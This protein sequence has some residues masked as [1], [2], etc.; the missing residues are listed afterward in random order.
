MKAIPFFAVLAVWATFTRPVESQQARAEVL[1]LG[2]YH[3][4]NPGRDVF[5]TQVD[6][7]LSPRRQAEMTELI[8]VL[9]KFNPTK[10]AVEANF[11]EQRLAQQ[12]ADYRAGKC[13]LSRNEIQQIGFRLARELGHDSVYAVDAD[14][15][16]P[17]M[18]VAGYAKASGRAAEFDALMA[19]IGA[20]VKEEGAYFASHTILQSLLYLNSDD[21]VRESVGFYFRE[22]HFGEAWDWAGA[23][24]LADWFKR[25][26]R[27]YSNVVQITASPAERV[28]V[29]F[30]AGHLGWLRPNFAS[31]PAYRLRTLAEFGN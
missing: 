9:K 3:M 13:D 20:M 29:I 28:L 31:D 22:A 8:A 15:E 12:Y 25:N 7:V 18:R 17:H 19:E 11:G 26:I 27:I 23:D 14:G 1:V 30:G 5:N 10:V 6:D 24:L 21:K 2:V 4:A 16:F